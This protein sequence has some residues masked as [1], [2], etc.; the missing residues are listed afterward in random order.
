MPTKPPDKKAENSTPRWQQ[1]PRC[2]DNPAHHGV[3][4]V[5]HGSE[6]AKKYL[7]CD[8]CGFTWSAVVQNKVVSERIEYREPEPLSQR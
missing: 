8:K 5:Y 3:G 7:K 2:Y 1:C 4:N 6:H